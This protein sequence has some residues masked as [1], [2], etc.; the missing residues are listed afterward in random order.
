MLEQNTNLQVAVQSFDSRT[1][2]LTIIAHGFKI[3]KRQHPVRANPQKI[4]EQFHRLPAHH[5]AAVVAHVAAKHPVV[6]KATAVK[7]GA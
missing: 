1:V 3:I 5:Q 2:D 7:A 6:A 4:I